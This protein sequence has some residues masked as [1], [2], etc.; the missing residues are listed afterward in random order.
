[1]N[2]LLDFLADQQ[3]LKESAQVAR[4]GLTSV[5]NTAFDKASTGV[6]YVHIEPL[7]RSLEEFGLA[8]D[9]IEQAEDTTHRLGRFVLVAILVLLGVLI[10]GALGAYLLLYFGV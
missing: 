6:S 9:S 1:M 2:Q 8:D 10:G 7:S 5:A 4:Q 3:S